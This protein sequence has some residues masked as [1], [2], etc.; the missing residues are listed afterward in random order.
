LDAS[1]GFQEA[2]IG[3]MLKHSLHFRIEVDDRQTTE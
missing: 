3:W 1:F 2:V